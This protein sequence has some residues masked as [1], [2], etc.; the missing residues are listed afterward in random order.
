MT[1]GLRRSPQENAMHVYIIETRH[2]DG[3]KPI[4]VYLNREAALKEGLVYFQQY[5]HRLYELIVWETEPRAVSETLQRKLVKHLATI[6]GSGIHL[7]E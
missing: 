3:G 2:S 7:V 5:S 4:A 1:Y 6:D